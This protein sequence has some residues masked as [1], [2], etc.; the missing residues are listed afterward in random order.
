M[1]SHRLRH[2]I[3]VAT[4]ASVGL[5]IS[6]CGQKGPLYMP[7]E[8]DEEKQEQETISAPKPASPSGT[9]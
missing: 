3:V 9:N 5:L 1:F 8:A 2:L 6:A 7:V 4:L